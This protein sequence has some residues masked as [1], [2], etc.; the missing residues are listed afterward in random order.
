M[1]SEWGIP[2][3]HIE[4]HWTDAQFLAFAD[5]LLERL[6]SQSGDKP[7]PTLGEREFLSRVRSSQWQ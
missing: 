2:F 1:M 4:A 5:L 6:R 3:D 7:K